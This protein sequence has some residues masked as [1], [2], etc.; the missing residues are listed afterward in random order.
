MKI[1]LSF[2]R[3][4]EF[5]LTFVGALTEMLRPGPEA[6][7][8]MLLSIFSN[9]CTPASFPTPGNIDLTLKWLISNT[10]IPEEQDEI[11]GL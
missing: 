11:A 4:H 8:D 1:F 2:S 5:Y 6:H 3:V 9:V 10:D 7:S